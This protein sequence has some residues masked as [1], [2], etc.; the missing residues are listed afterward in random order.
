MLPPLC[1]GDILLAYSFI[2]D[3][4][5]RDLS[6]KQRAILEHPLWQAVRSG[7]ASYAQLRTFAL[8][9]DWLVRHS[10]QLEALLLAHAPDEAARNALLKKWS[11]KTV[12]TSQ[13]AEGSLRRFGAALGL[14]NAD[15]EGIQP[16]AGCAALTTHFYYALLNGGFAA[17]LASLT[18]SES[19]FMELCRLAGPALREKYGLTD[20]QV[21]F[22]PLH[23]RLHEG[24][25]V[26]EV[27]LL[28]RLSRTS[29]DCERLT[30][31]VSLTYDCERLFYDTVYA[32]T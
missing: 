18:A 11:A 21:A 4:L 7:Q 5:T 26:Q 17:M 2:P 14:T 23:D 13:G 9:D 1:R 12:F 10:P 6:A 32:A 29:E 3:L 22:F 31:A 28:R 25:N 30:Q 15:F 19:I 16:L 8:Q 20:E 24:V 27:A